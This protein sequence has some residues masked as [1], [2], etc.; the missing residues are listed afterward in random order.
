M[1]R[2]ALRD[3]G[4]CSLKADDDSSLFTAAGPRSGAPVGPFCCYYSMIQMFR[5]RSSVGSLRLKDKHTQT[6]Y[7]SVSPD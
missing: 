5:S 6:R 7:F 1:S 4:S 3:A 2:E